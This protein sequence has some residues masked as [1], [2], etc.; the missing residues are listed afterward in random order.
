MAM[1]LIQEK[2]GI[3]VVR[4]WLK[5][6]FFTTCLSSIATFGNAQSD[7]VSFNPL[8][9]RSI[10]IASFD[11]LV[12]CSAALLQTKNLA[13]ISDSGH[14][15]IMMCLNT[16]VFTREI[17]DFKERFIHEK[18]QR[19]LRISEEKDYS[20]NITKVYPKWIPNRGMGFYFPKLK[21]ELYGIPM[22]YAKFNVRYF[23]NC[24]FTLTDSSSGY[25]FVLDS[26]HRI[27]SAFEKSGRP[28]WK[29][30]P[31]KEGIMTSHSIENPVVVYIALGWTHDCH[32]CRIPVDSRVIWIR[33]NNGQMGS[34]DLLTGSFRSGGQTSGFSI[35]IKSS[36]NDE[37][38]RLFPG[39]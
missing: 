17:P 39:H 15:Q 22:P 6:V 10:S 9:S 16:I 38:C 21:M 35:H 31:S 7:S 11:S 32:W 33:Y 34:L 5:L 27:I 20:R 1:K 28:L 23:E 14:I 25:I 36:T 2:T 3:Q 30:D 4:T 18:Y 24:D 19:L 13:E 26:T 29:T 12:D 8:V 37:I